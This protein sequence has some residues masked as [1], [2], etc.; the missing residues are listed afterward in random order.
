MIFLVPAK[1]RQLNC[2]IRNSTKH[3]KHFLFYIYSFLNCWKRDHYKMDNEW[4]VLEGASPELHSNKK[5][6]FS[7][8]SNFEPKNAGAFKQR[9]CF[10]DSQFRTLILSTE[11]RLIM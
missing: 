3:R 11:Q 5:N 7:L 2:D 4:N 1:F 9:H 10:G 8:E 6:L